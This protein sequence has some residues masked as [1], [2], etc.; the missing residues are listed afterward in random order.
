MLLSKYE[1]VQ[2]LATRVKQLNAG[3]QAAVSFREG[4]STYDIA[5]R[6][7]EQGSMPVQCHQDYVQAK[8]NTGRHAE[9]G[10]HPDLPQP[11]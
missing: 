9:R 10:A 7:L 3:A 6:E 8:E 2:V 4:E 1:R 5:V 11:S